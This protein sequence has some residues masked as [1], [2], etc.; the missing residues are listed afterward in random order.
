M[1]KIN[2]EFIKGT[3]WA[4]AGLMSL[5]GF[6]S[7]EK[8]T[9]GGSTEEYGTPYAEFVVSGKVTDADDQGLQGIGVIVSKVDH[10]QRTTSSFIPDRDVITH[11]VRDT[12]RTSANGAFEYHYNGTPGNDSVNVHIKFEDLSENARF[13]ADSAKVTFFGS[14]LKGGERWYKGRAEKKISIKLK[15]KGK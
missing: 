10:H 4:L 14:D 2:R 12:S 6:S 11:E 5:L 8:I 9:N 1:K 13:E 15:N 7:C 3:N